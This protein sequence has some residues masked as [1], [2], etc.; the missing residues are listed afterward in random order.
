MAYSDIINYSSASRAFQF[1]SLLNHFHFNCYLFITLKLS[2]IPQILIFNLNFITH[3][4]AEKNKLTEWI[5]IKK[6]LQLIAP[7][8]LCSPLFNELLL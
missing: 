4:W 3:H 6:P 7:T 5:F 1:C 2:T 8:Y